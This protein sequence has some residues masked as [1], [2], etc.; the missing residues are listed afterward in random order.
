MRLNTQSPDGGA[1]LWGWGRGNFEQRE[2]KELGHW[3][4]GLEG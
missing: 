4:V 3:R 2:L 1:T